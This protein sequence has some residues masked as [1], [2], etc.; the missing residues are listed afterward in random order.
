DGTRIQ[1]H[2][3]GDEFHA[4]FETLDG[5]TVVFDPASKAYDY[6]QLSPDG[7]ALI[8][9][10]ARVGRDDPAALGLAK[11]LRM[12][13]EA[14]KQQVRQRYQEW[15]QAMEVSRRWNEL[16]AA[17]GQ[18]AP[19]AQ[20]GRL[21][22]LAPPSLPTVGLKV[23]FTILIDFSDDPATIPQADVIAY[24]NDTGYT[25]YG[26]NGSVKDYFYDNSGGLLTYTNT[27]TFYIR[28][29]QPKSFYND[30]SKGC[31][32]CAGNLL[33]DC[34]NVMT[35]LP[36][37]ET[38]ILPLLEPLTVDSNNRVVACNVFFAGNSSGVWAYGLWPCSTSL[39]TPV[40]LPGS[41]KSLNKF[42][43]TNIG[44]A[45]RI[46]TFCHENGHMLC[47]FPDIYDYDVGADDSRGGAGSFC[48]MDSSGSSTNPCQFCAYLKRAAGWAT[49]TELTLW[50]SGTFAVSSS[51]PGFN[52]FYRF[53]KPGVPT[54]YFLV[55]NRQKSGRDA[56]LPAA[57]IAIW[58]IDELGDKDDQSLV[59]NI[60][61]ANYEVTL[62]QADNL[63]HF[64]RNINSGDTNDLYYAGNTAAGYQNA[65]TDHTGPNARWWDGTL[66]GVRFRDFSENGSTMTFTVVGWD[67]PGEGGTTNVIDGITVNQPGDYMVGS[68]GAF[69]ALVI[70]NA[71]V[72]AVTHDSLVG[73]SPFASN[74]A[75]W[76]TGPGSVWNNA[77]NLYVGAF[78]AGNSLTITN[79][80]RVLAN[81]AAVGLGA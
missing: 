27:V 8:P 32:T 37:Y 54:E 48:I 38:D 71:G 42:Q 78:G 74:N 24:C 77:S 52:H 45:L 20:D 81:S 2:G 17:R 28:A 60:T 22:V 36:N 4:V 73:Y 31:G 62:V 21:M 25:G 53:A 63:W 59:P 41:G 40:S 75:A 64:Q 11:H 65:F 33:R 5:Y 72:L 15:D 70:T 19:A 23:G 34:L 30:T 58:H 43:I 14:V 68:N 39:G 16:K 76:V 55:E 80:A 12:S 66:S 13:P 49:T 29:P 18:A 69:Y 47:G 7:I 44:S 10:G 67:P 6:A 3:W 51:G 26:N 9:T 35:N 46:S 50:S 57:G 61:H 56:V 1:L 79:A